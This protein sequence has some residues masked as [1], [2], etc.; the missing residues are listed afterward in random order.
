MRIFAF[1][2]ALALLSPVL[3]VAQTP[4]DSTSTPTSTPTSVSSVQ[5]PADEYFG[6]TG[7]SVLEIRN[8][9]QYMERQN[10]TELLGSQNALDTMNDLQE[11]IAD[12][13][14]QY[15]QDPWVPGLLSRLVRCYARIHVTT[16]AHAI[17]AL[18]LLL[19]NY[20][21]YAVTRD[22]LAA[23][24]NQYQPQIQSVSSAS[25]PPNP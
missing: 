19:V 11:A 17:R 16:D 8:R 6:R 13:H 3:A 2:F 25:V 5:A 1:A 20:P 21:D 18:G 15:P 23:I 4:E 24:G 7:W 9:I 10:D 12:W 22:A 14:T